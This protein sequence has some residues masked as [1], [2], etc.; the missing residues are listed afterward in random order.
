MY[1]SAVSSVCRPLILIPQQSRVCWGLRFI[2]CPSRLFPLILIVHEFSMSRPG[3]IISDFMYNLFAS[4][5]DFAPQTHVK[6][7]ILCLDWEITVTI[8]SS[9]EAFTQ[10]ILVLRS[11]SK[12]MQCNCTSCFT[13]PFIC[14]LLYLS[15][16]ASTYQQSGKRDNCICCCTSLLP[17]G[18]DHIMHLSY[19][20]GLSFIETLLTLFGS[21]YFSSC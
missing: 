1:P 16:C 15:P 3:T 18:P 14:F 20:T 12:Q 8:P 9:T 21:F 13:P 19:F 11:N 4:F 17:W 6:N 5:I 10:L 2:N 7:L